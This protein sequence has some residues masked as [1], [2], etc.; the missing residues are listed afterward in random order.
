MKKLI[1][2]I[3]A[4]A[5]MTLALVSCQKNAETEEPAR[6]QS[7]KFYAYAPA[8]KTVFGEP[9][10]SSTRVTY[11]T[12]WTATNKIKISQNYAAAVDATVVPS[13]DGAS[14]EFVPESDITDD[15]SGEYT[16]FALSPASV[17]YSAISDKFL[18]WSIEIPASQKPIE[19]SADENAQIL[20]AKANLG[21]KFPETVTFDFQ[22][23]TAYGKL[24]LINLALD[25][26]ETVSTIT[27]T[28]NA[29]MAGRFRY[30]VEGT[31]ANPEGSIAPNGASDTITLE[32]DQTENV[33]FACAPGATFTAF[34]VVVATDKGT[35]T[36]QIDKLT[37]EYTMQRGH[38]AGITVDMEGITR[39]GSIIYTLVTDLADLTVGSEIIIANENATKAISTT[40]NNNNRAAVDVTRDGNTIPNPSPAVQVF[41]LEKGTVDNTASFSTGEGYIFAASSSANNLRTETTKSG[42]SSWTVAISEGGVATVVAQGSNTR[43]NLRYNSSNT[44]FSAYAESSSVKEKVSLYKRNGSGSDTKI[45]DGGTPDTPDDPAGDSDEI[46]F[47][48]L[49]LSNGVQYSS[50]SNSTEEFTVSFAGGTND[51]TYYN[52]GTGIRTY[53]GGTITVSSSDRTITKIEY[54]W[55][56]DY[57]PES[58][59]V[60]SP[61]TYDVAT[62]TWTGSATTVTLTR[63]SGSGHWRLQKVK[64]TFDGPAVTKVVTG[65]T[66]GVGQAGATLKGSFSGA[67]GRIGEAGFEWGTSASSLTETVYDDTVLGERSSG[68]Y[69]CQITSLAA[70]T[71]YYY[72]AFVAEY[73]E[74]TSKYEYRYGEVKSFTTLAEG[75][76]PS[77]VAGWLELPAASGNYDFTGTFFDGKARNYS[78]SYSY[79]WWASMWVAYP[80]IKE[81]TEGSAGTSSWIANPDFDSDKQVSISKSYGTMY[82]NGTYSRGH[83]IPHGD[84]KGNSTMSRQT[85]YFTNQTPQIQEK[86]NGTVWQQLENGIRDILSGSD[87]VYVATGPVYRTV[88][89]NESITY[90]TGASGARPASLPVANYYWKA[91][92]KVKWGTKNGQQVVTSASAIGFWFE[93]KEYTKGDSDYAYA[94]H[95]CKVS[96]IEAKTGLDLFANLP[97]DLEATAEANGSWDSFKSF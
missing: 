84:R 81:Y 13:S 5:A 68:S 62:S 37:S 33:F 3:L 65:G 39:D 28:T 67:T 48:T 31:D 74:E 51:G 83:Q 29:E 79:T 97:D 56:S 7:V 40:Q 27:I 50:F 70:K 89:G 2:I 86:F 57:A 8:T 18:N 54:T 10:T 11:P 34:K 96:E 24:S 80:L 45:F 94:T 88:G 52:T 16:F 30:Y 60:A 20:F 46:D 77:D 42:N 32:T 90:L 92:L 23:V 43:N 64:V 58:A 17:E 44:I 59:S 19:G 38:I 35:Y 15:G 6:K 22:H 76:T 91:L 72:R 63:P 36:K 9:N 25:E 4:G 82:N 61:A 95:A 73:N 26:D 47:S 66:E 1:N 14:A 49:G 12:L 75:E 78:Y 53:G 69:S 55:S 93:H 85:Y 21:T 87:T 71:T 41:T